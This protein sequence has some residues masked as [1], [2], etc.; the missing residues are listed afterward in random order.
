MKYTRTNELIKFIKNNNLF[1]EFNSIHEICTG[2][3]SYNFCVQTAQKKYLLK[4]MNRLDRFVR[5]KLILQKLGLLVK[6]SVEDFSE[7]EKLLAIPYIEGRR[8][9][10]NDV[11][12]ELLTF[13]NEQYQQLQKLNTENVTILPQRALEN[14]K[15][16]IELLL[17]QDKSWTYQLIKKYFWNRCKTT[18]INM[19]TSQEV[20]H[21][22]MT[23]NNILVDVN[24]KPHL[25]DFEQVRFGYA[26]EDY[27]GL[28]LQIAGFR[29]LYGSIKKL[30][31]LVLMMLGCT[32]YTSMELLYGVQCFYL[33][34][35]WRR[36]HNRS[37]KKE[38]VRKTLCLL[39]CLLGYFRVRKALQENIRS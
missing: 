35:L 1:H 38:N 39:I 11:S 6:L 26:S 31:K 33:H 21:G 28:F 14:M 10:L 20:I 4:V 23:A 36:L 8:I 9:L 17:A 32:T 29:G 2:G 7:N 5:L 19:P 3:S 27:M 18:L 37:S 15:Q 22:D 16:E 12:V 25:L 13:L 30:K 34:L 24:G